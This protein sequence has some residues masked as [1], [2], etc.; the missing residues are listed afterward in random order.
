MQSQTPTFEICD[1]GTE[2]K[3]DEARTWPHKHKYEKGRTLCI[4][5]THELKE[6]ELR[7]K[8]TLKGK[9]VSRDFFETII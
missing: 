1:N 9:K 4:N 7:P 8:R 2:S 6:R 3:V 5:M